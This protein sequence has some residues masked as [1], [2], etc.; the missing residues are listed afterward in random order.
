MNLL[1]FFTFEN[2][3]CVYYYQVLLLLFDDKEG[4]VRRSLAFHSQGLLP[5]VSLY[6]LGTKLVPRERHSIVCRSTQKHEFVL[7]WVSGLHSNTEVFSFTIRPGTGRLCKGSRLEISRN[8]YLWT[9]TG[10]HKNSWTF[11][12]KSGLFSFKIIEIPKETRRK[13]RMKI[14]NVQL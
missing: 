4:N 10:K 5:S 2:K 14:R 3:P 13:W 12:D 8:L 1:P 7:T 9:F 6:T 11:W